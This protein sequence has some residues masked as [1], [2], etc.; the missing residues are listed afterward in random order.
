MVKLEH[1]A[2]VAVAERHELGIRQRRQLVLVDDDR[3]L[4]GAIE[5][6]KHVQQRALA[7]ARC[8]DDRDHLARA[9]RQVEIAQHV[10]SS[11]TA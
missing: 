2:D 4:L 6:A 3:A 5:P 7:D 10:R 11:A 9:R 8:A 1:E